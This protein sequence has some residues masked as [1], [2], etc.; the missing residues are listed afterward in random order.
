MMKKNNRIKG[1]MTN[2]FLG[3]IFFLLLTSH[4]VQAQSAQPPYFEKV[5]VTL[6]P[7]Y[8]QPSILV[9][10][11]I[12]LP[13]STSM[14]TEV[15]L[16]LPQGVHDIENLTELIPD[17]EFNP[18][19]YK[20]VIQEDNTELRFTPQ[21]KDFQV[22][23]YDAN[24]VKDGANRSYIFHWNSSLVVKNIHLRVLRPV[25]ASEVEIYPELSVNVIGSDGLEYYEDNFGRVEAGEDFSLELSYV[26]ELGDLN[27]PALIVISGD[28]IDSH[29]AGQTPKPNSLMLALLSIASAGVLGLLIFFSLRFA[30]VR[31]KKVAD[32]VLPVE[33]Q[34]NLFKPYCLECG[35]RLEK[36]DRFCR[37]CGAVLR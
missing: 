16:N 8:D 15:I 37:S 5:S 18:G 25:G 6:Y 3:F 32:S 9:S 14:P 28:P 2:L 10:Y 34:S 1:Y 7:E 27:N 20:V 17:H 19:E 11:A 23:F 30:V 33:E 21:S 36:G 26:K 13:D 35:H 4:S 31:K 12:S 29:T 24:L 22:T